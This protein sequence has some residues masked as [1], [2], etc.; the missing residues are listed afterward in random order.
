MS[1]RT[2][3]CDLPQKEQ[4][5]SFPSL[6]FLRT[7]SPAAWRPLLSVL[8]VVGIELRVDDLVDEAVLARLLGAH[9]VVA[10]GVL[11]D[12]LDRLAGVRGQDAVE[13]LLPLQDLAG[14]DLDVRRLAAEP[15]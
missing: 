2:S 1:F 12:L 6:P 10:L 13:R 4:Q 7:A 5:R 8:L 9:D 3:F 11:G 14:V 15:A